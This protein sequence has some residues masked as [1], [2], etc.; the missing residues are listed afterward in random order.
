[1]KIG[2]TISAE[3]EKTI[4]ESERMSLRK[5]EE[6]RKKTSVV[7]FFLML[8]LITVFILGMVMN[9]VSERKKNDIP[10]VE[11][12]E[13][14][15]TIEIIDESGVGYITDKIKTYVG[16]LEIDF[17]DLGYS[18]VKAIIPSGKTREIDVYVNDREEFY[19]C[20]LDRGTAETAEDAIRMIKYLDEKEIK[21]VYVD[22][23]IAGR[24]YY[25]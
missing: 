12:K 20:H 10:V 24:A 7:I 9:A 22:V 2:K 16:K 3:R 23:R 5:K 25:K 6:K 1:M 14:K 18:L 17:K 4:S 15:P 19:K 8:I 13:Y 21:P 11:E